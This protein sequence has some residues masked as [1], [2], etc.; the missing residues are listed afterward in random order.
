VATYASPPQLVEPVTSLASAAFMT[1]NL[2]RQISPL[3]Q[4]NEE[5]LGLLFQDRRNLF[6]KLTTSKPFE[7]CTL[8]VI[9]F[10]AIW[11]GVDLELNHASTWTEADLTFAVADNFFCGF[12]T[13]EVSLRFCAFRRCRTLCKDKSFW[14]DFFLVS[15]MILETWV[16]AFMSFGGTSTEEPLVVGN[17]SVEVSEE[18]SNVRQVGA[19]WRVLTRTLRLLRL[20]RMVRLMRAVPELL[21]LLK[22]TLAAVRAVGVNFLILF[23]AMFFFAVIFVSQYRGKEG[24]LGEEYFSRVGIAMVTLFVNGTIMDELTSVLIALLDDSLPYYCLFII[25]VLLSSLTILNMLVGVLCEVVARVTESEKSSTSFRQMETTLM[26]VFERVDADGNGKIDGVEFHEMLCEEDSPVR[27]ALMK[28]GM[29]EDRLW[30]VWRQVF[31]EVDAPI[32]ARLRRQDSYHDGDDSDASHEDDDVTEINAL[33]AVQRPDTPQSGCEVTSQ[34]S[35]SPCNP[36]AANAA[37]AA[38]THLAEQPPLSSGLPAAFEETDARSEDSA[39]PKKGRV[40]L[41]RSTTFASA[42]PDAEQMGHMV[43]LTFKEFIDELILL[44]PGGGGV[45]LRGFAALR[46]AAL[47]VS[48]EGAEK[49]SDI[50]KDMATVANDIAA[51][52]A[53][54][55]AR[56]LAERDRKATAGKQEQKALE[57][58]QRMRERLAEKELENDTLPGAMPA[59]AESRQQWLNGEPMRP[60]ASGEPMRPATS[61]KPIRPAT[62]GEPIRPSTSGAVGSLHRAHSIA[63]LLRVEEELPVLRPATA[64]APQRSP[65]FHSEMRRKLLPVPTDMLIAELSTRLSKSVTSEI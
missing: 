21:I 49:V 7:S 53:R 24:V 51:A 48:R 42:A 54:V 12:F 59:T 60:V 19:I 39:T 14:F 45:S 64:G 6:E 38:N 10:N 47:Q 9:C 43:E 16:F 31:V 34:A 35:D 22:G 41:A 32:G 2:G 1:L 46:R 3:E 56:E 18:G 63:S 50:A 17:R 62:S 20:T 25:F 57:K 15:M 55:R 13:L 65:P 26:Q 11:I 33:L 58:A 61:G 30:D 8:L 52:G 40:G 5:D 44:R 4:A 36:T 28:I 27:K 29:E 37:H 23:G